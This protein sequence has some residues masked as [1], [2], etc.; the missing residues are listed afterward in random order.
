MATRFEKAEDIQKRVNEIV[1]ALEMGHVNLPNVVCL[2]SNGSK[3]KA[4]A[5]C[6]EFPRVWQ[7]ALDQPPHYIIEVIGERFDK[8]T[9]EEQEK[10]LIH[11]L[12]HI[13]NNFSG[14]LRPHGSI[15]GKYLD[16]KIDNM[17]QRLKEYRK[18]KDKFYM[19][20]QRD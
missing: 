6:W 5:R 9:S 16:R 19:F 14:H 18:N 13:P 15:L 17:H 10:I 20:S 12:M 8:K 4:Y 1:E 2:R 7:L 11:E 3:T